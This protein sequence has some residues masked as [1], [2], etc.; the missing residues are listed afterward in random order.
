MNRKGVCLSMYVCVYWC[1]YVR[2]LS[3]CLVYMHSVCICMVC[4]ACM[5]GCVCMCVFAYLVYVLVHICVMC[6]WEI[7][8]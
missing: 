2:V 4:V 3:V 1:V 8:T 6:I 5:Y 7:S